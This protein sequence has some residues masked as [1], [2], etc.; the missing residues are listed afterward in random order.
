MSLERTLSSRTSLLTIKVFDYF[1]A[2]LTVG[3]IPSPKSPLTI[4]GLS[5]EW[6]VAQEG[7]LSVPTAIAK[8]MTVSVPGSLVFKAQRG[9]TAAPTRPFATDGHI[10]L[11]GQMC[12]IERSVPDFQA[13]IKVHLQHP[14]ELTE[15]KYLKCIEIGK[16]TAICGH[17]TKSQDLG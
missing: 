9:Q 13:P 17:V 2:R 16:S 5:T 14:V 10:K 1:V 8:D 12:K 3:E 6:F 11:F 4:F 15:F 7:G